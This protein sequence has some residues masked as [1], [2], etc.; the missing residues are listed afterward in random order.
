MKILVTYDIPR[1]PFV[2][3]PADWKITFPEGEKLSKEEIIRLL[4]E[5]DILLAIFS[6]PIDKDML[7][8]GKKLQLI[9]SATTTSTFSMRGKK[10]LQYAIPL[11]RF[12]TRQ[13]NSAWP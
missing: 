2:N 6:R 11:S 1:E 12:A 5:Y 9:R 13:Q 4:P 7:D 3:L 10:G 8:A